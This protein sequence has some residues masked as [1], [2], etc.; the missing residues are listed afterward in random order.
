MRILVLGLTFAASMFCGGAPIR[1]HP[2]NPHYFLLRGRPTVLVTSGEHYG[3][4]VNLDFDYR[5]YLRALAADRLNLTR[6]F[7]G[8]YRERAG[9]FN[10][11]GNTLAP[12][13]GR[14]IA[15]WPE[16][17]GKFDLSRWNGAYFARLKDFLREASRRGVV[18]E[19]NLFCPYYEDSMWELS[20]LN[21]KN[22]VNG[23][24]SV[25][26][27]EVLTLQDARLVEVQ[28]AM[29]R[30]IV[31]E[32]RDFDNLYYEIC[33]EPYFAG[34][35]EEWQRHMA[36]TIADAE[37]PFPSRHLISQNIANGSKK[38]ENPIPEVSL[39]N[40]HYTRPPGAVSLNYG[41]NKAIGCNETGFD[42]TAD[43]IYRLQG[44]D[45][46]M[47]GGALYN[48]LDY[49]FTVGHEAGDYAVPASQPG[50][51]SAA[52]RR[53]LGFLRAFLDR[54]PLPRMAPA[55]ELVAAPPEDASVRLLA[56]PGRVYAAYLH[57]GRVTQDKKNRYAV[58]AASRPSRVGFRLDGGNY[59]AVWWSPAG[60]KQVQRQRVKHGGGTLTL[61][62]PAYSE[63][64]ALRLAAR[65]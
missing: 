16:N 53:Q 1:L 23:I 64:I 44:W 60:G 30:K 25:K 29:V 28:D 14:F 4:V 5:K 7:A 9:N 57:R 18:V 62:S 50:G 10:I 47:A 65:R 41:L 33:N 59:E 39:F 21:A 22:N 38:V 6:T 61:E 34:V 51:G 27:T 19:L 58:D 20:P 40:F 36:R 37:A 55:S 45:F 42:G 43:S 48:N 15:P 56:Q 31:A 12:A 26:R 8:A 63:D 52:L 46:L 11:A 13:A 54:L 3:A 49:S 24:G 17:A 32:L 35:T 2:Q